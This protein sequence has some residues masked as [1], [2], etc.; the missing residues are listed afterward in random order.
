MIETFFGNNALNSP[1]AFLSALII[2]IAFGW[3]LEQ[4]G[5]G[6]SRKLSGIFYFR[7][8][9]VLKVMFSAVITTILGLGIL[10]GTG[11][12]RA[13]SIFVPDTIL[14]AQVVGGLIFGIGFV[15][16]GWCPG[17]AA[18]GAS[19]GKIDAI[20]FIIGALLGSYIFNL[21]FGYL[22]F[23]YSY[24][25]L[26]TSFIYNELGF[27]FSDFALLATVV[28]VF[29]FWFSELIEEKFSFAAVAARGSGLWVFS[30]IALLSGCL[31]MAMGRAPVKSKETAGQVVQSSEILR[32]IESGEDHIEPVTMAR[33]ILAGQK[34]IAIV[35][36]RTREEYDEWHIPGAV[37]ALVPS[38]PIAIE[39]YRAHDRIVFY[40]NLSVHSAQAWVVA[41]KSGLANVYILTG[42]VNGFFE[43]VL[44]PV[45]LRSVEVTLEERAEINKWRAMFRGAGMA[46]GAAEP[47]KS[48]VPE[49]LKEP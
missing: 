25:N 26:G 40:S 39:R 11:L 47:V 7:D 41:R 23:W 38:L 22:G 45:S 5:F 2:G 35:D 30:V 37:H 9:S 31:V 8:M 24:G 20:F 1:V 36:L 17:T 49:N 32:Q 48:I 16:G 34:K 13:E 33:E 18:V 6:S 3:C 44:Q 46:V 12:L 43:E 14:G 10:I 42:G 4:A 27:R 29:S 28:A 15:I 21:S 19:S